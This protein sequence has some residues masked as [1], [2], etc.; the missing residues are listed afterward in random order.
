MKSVDDTWTEIEVDLSNE[1]AK[2]NVEKIREYVGEV[3][4]IKGGFSNS[5]MRNL[6]KKI[7][8]KSRDP[9]M[10]KKDSEG[11]LVTDPQLL[12]K[13]VLGYLCT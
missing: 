4:N 9:P 13:I 1:C 6:M 3:C 5:G 11:N 2:K 10:A 7:S 8:L 12:K